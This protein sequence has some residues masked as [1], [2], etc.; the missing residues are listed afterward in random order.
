MLSDHFPKFRTRKLGPGEVV[1]KPTVQLPTSCLT[2][3]NVS[4]SFGSLAAV[5]DVSFEVTRGEVFGI[6]GPNGAG[7][8]TLFNMITG[9]PFHSDQ[10]EIWFEGSRIDR[11]PPYRIFR[12]GLARTF[13]QE[14]AFD[15]LTVNASVRLAN[16]YSARSATRAEAED[17]VAHALDIT[18]LT[19]MAS[20]L[21]RDLAFFEKKR[22]MLATA[23]ASGPRLLMMDEPAAG[24][25]HGEGQLLVELVKKISRS[26][27]TIVIIEHVLPILFG[28]SDRLMILDSGQ[29]LTIDEP[30]RVAKDTRVI[31]AYLGERGRGKR[32]K[33]AAD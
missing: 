18:G 31:D 2:V 24:L 13:Q 12:R 5:R 19:S 20:Q 26:G 28:V 27:F 17:H 11:V 22:L 6:A 15:S 10:G 7:K 30:A 23:L 3:V 21:S 14:R 4:K 8:T 29:V 32:A 33:Y 1:E 16:H 9:L 25:S